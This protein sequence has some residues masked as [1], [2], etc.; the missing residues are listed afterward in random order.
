MEDVYDVSISDEEFKLPIAHL[1]MEKSPEKAG[2]TKNT[3]ISSSSSD[4]EM[5]S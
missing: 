2:P 3:S 4:K 5:S 1:S